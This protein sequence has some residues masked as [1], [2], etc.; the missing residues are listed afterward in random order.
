M[1]NPILFVCKSCRLSS[2]NDEAQQSDGA[3]LLNQLLALHQQWSRQAKIEIQPVSCLW[4]CRQACT[5]ALQSANKCTYL[6]T[7][8]PSESAAALLQFSELYLDSKDGNIPWKKIPEVLKTET[9][10]RIPTSG[11]VIE[12]ED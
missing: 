8:L 9:I 3:L 11:Q 1:S 2:H 6:F 10:A 4:I 12:D 7:H 5:V